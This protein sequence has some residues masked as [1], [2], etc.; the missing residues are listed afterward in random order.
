MPAAHS[1]PKH[2]PRTTAGNDEHHHFHPGWKSLELFTSGFASFA[3]QS[4]AFV[5]SSFSSLAA[6]RRA[7]CLI[8]CAGVTSS[9]RGVSS[10]KTEE[11]PEAGDV[12]MDEVRDR[13]E[14]LGLLEALPEMGLALRLEPMAHDRPPVPVPVQSSEVPLPVPPPAAPCADRLF[15]AVH[16]H[17]TSTN[18]MYKMYRDANCHPIVEFATML[19]PWHVGMVTPTT[20]YSSTQLV[21][22]SHNLN[23]TSL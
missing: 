5:S 20:V 22:R 12:P 18:H 17:C 19:H 10:K 3:S 1:N 13:E 6:Q 7:S 21:P 2:F 9:S 16:P 14:G 23:T 4:V 15:T 11:L 8:C